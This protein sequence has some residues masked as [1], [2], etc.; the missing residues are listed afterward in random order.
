M[1]EDTD[2]LEFLGRCQ[3]C[4]ENAYIGNGRKPCPTGYG[5]GQPLFEHNCLRFLGLKQR[6]SEASPKP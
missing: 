1:A 4:L 6:A 5:I 2:E 3:T